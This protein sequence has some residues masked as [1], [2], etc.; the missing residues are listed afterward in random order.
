[1]MPTQSLQVHV[2]N[3]K[4]KIFAEIR[5]LESSFAEHSDEALDHYMFR[6]RYTIR[7]KKEGCELLGKHFYHEQFE[8][9]HKLTGRDLVALKKR[10]SYPYLL[11]QKKLYLFGGKDIFLL[12]LHGKDLKKWLLKF[13]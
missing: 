10:M 2:E 11:N 7:L 6:N 4:A 12:K 3:A 13:H 9:D 1:M 8:L 5:Q